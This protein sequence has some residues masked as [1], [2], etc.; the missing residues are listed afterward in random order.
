VS[1]RNVARFVVLGAALGTLGGYSSYAMRQSSAQVADPATIA[2]ALASQVPNRA[3][4]AS[5]L[6][7]LV[8]VTLAGDQVATYSLASISPG[9]EFGP[10][11]ETDG[12]L[13]LRRGEAVEAVPQA[14]PKIDEAK[15]GPKIEI[16][17]ELKPEIK[18]AT[19]TDV[20][21]PGAKAKRLPAPA[22]TSSTLLD[23][24]QIAGLKSRLRLTAEQ[25]EFWP[26]VEA[27]LREVAR[28]QLRPN[29]LKHVHGKPS[30][31][32]NAPEVQQL[33]SAAMPLLTRLR[34]DQKLEVRKLARIIGLDQVAS[35]I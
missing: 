11:R 30:I 15:S 13:A 4:K 34:E 12:S 2:Q 22:R 21:L 25:L 9:A 19:L 28:T 27:A 14:E 10:S 24:S 18:V 1:K 32:V 20:P 16:K 8:P 5:R 26:A 23:D 7:K 17:P 6:A 31:D 35:Q 29:H 33:I 3:A